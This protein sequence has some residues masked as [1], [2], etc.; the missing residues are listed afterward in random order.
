MQTKRW[1]VQVL[2]GMLIGCVCIASSV[3]AEGGNGATSGAKETPSKASDHAT[4][5][6]GTPSTVQVPVPVTPPPASAQ[7]PPVSSEPAAPQAVVPSPKAGSNAHVR[8][9]LNG[10]SWSL[11]LIMVSGSEKEKG[12]IQKDTVTFGTQTI[13]S[14]RLTK[15]GFPTSN[16]SLTV[17]DDGVAVW[18]TMQTHSNGKGVAFWRGEI[19]GDAMEGVLSKQPTGGGA[20]EFSFTGHQI[21]EG[22]T[23]GGGAPQTSAT[24]HAEVSSSV[25]PAQQAQTQQGQAKKKR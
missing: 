3:L 19:H 21:G 16:Y 18:E 12:K 14:D 15:A 11:E 1:L 10:T 23:T 8:A 25:T 6:A 24:S 5:Q 20:E 7:L 13:S 4:S 2:L 17:G 9:R 22:A